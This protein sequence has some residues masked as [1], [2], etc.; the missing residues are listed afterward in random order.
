MTQGERTEVTLMIAFVDHRQTGEHN[1]G[2]Y[3]LNTFCRWLN[4]SVRQ[5]SV[6]ILRTSPMIIDEGVP[7]AVLTPLWPETPGQKN[8]I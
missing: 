6:W 4:G 8:N 7:S 5:R 2:A 3:R 1:N